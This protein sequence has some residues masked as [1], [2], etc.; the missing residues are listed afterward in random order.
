MNERFDFTC[1]L[2]VVVA[3]LLAAVVAVDSRC[4]FGQLSFD[5]CSLA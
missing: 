5:F 2:C 4:Y 3:A 1:A